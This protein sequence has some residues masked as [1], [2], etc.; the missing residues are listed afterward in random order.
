MIAQKPLFLFCDRGGLEAVAYVELGVGFLVVD[1]EV[2]G[3]AEAVVAVVD[4]EGEHVAA[5]AVVGGKACEGVDAEVGAAVVGRIVEFWVVAI[6]GFVLLAVGLGIEFGAVHQVGIKR[7]HGHRREVE[8][9]FSTIQRVVVAVA[10]AH[11]HL[12]G[13]VNVEVGDQ[14]VFHGVAALI[15]VGIHHHT[16]RAALLH[17]VGKQ[18][19]RERK[20][21]MIEHII[22]F[23]KEDVDVVLARFYALVFHEVD[24][25]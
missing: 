20:F 9:Q 8:E 14:Y 2:F 1:V 13:A 22:A 19:S 16:S 3:V 6:H 15:I 5:E 21:A 18:T 25:L 23:T 12:L 24:Y 7:E 10:K 17:H 4:K 11:R